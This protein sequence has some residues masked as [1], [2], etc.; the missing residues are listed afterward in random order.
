M[1]RKTVPV[2]RYRQYAISRASLPF[3]SPDGTLTNLIFTPI[4]S[5]LLVVEYNNQE[6]T[7]SHSSWVAVA[8]EEETIT[9][10]KM[11]R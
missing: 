7:L 5:M 9:R 3:E 10:Q 6:A 2:A 4:F 8:V 11:W 1:A